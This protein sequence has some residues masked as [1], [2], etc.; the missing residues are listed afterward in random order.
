[1]VSFLQHFAV[2]R[3]VVNPLEKHDVVGITNY[4]DVCMQVR[5]GVGAG[6]RAGALGGAGM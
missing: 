4:I 1:M 5:G 2:A 6:A 3:R